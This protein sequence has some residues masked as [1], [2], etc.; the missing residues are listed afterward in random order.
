MVF[1]TAVPTPPRVALL[2]AIFSV[3][4]VPLVYGLGVALGSNIVFPGPLE[5]FVVLVFPYL[6]IVVMAYVGS[7]VVYGLGTAVRE[8]REMGSYRLVER[9]GQGGMGEVWRAEHRMLARPA[10]IKLIRP[11]ML[12]TTGSETRQVILR[13][14]ERE[15]RATALMR[16]P[17]TMELYDYGVAQDGTFYYVMELL[18][19]FDFKALVERFGAVPAER[20]IYLMVQLCDSLAEAHDARLIHRDVKPANIYLCRQGRSVDFVKVLDFGLVK[21]GGP[22]QPDQER[23][24]AEHSTS[25]TPGFMSP[26]QVMGAPEVDRR[27]DLYAVGCVGY[28][29]LTGSLVFE[30]RTSMEIM[31]RHVRDEPVPPS[32]RVELQVPKELDAVIMACLA[33]DPE[34]RPQTADELRALLEAVPLARPWGLDRARQWWDAHRPGGQTTPALT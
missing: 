15:A 2:T 29:L 25:G 1:T 11:E 26:E 16:S 24:T 34:L 13:R 28:W 8:A 32:R 3:S 22:M 18:D 27:S 6:L 4:A 12:G 5:Y 9:L 30:G 17:H 21:P 7:R 33:K 20:A 14:F 10:A 31:M 23:L 19:G